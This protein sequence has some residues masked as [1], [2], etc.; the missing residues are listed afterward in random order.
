MKHG[1]VYFGGLSRGD[2][3]PKEIPSLGAAGGRP[4]LSEMT[5]KEMEK[6]CPYARDEY[7]RCPARH[8][9]M[10]LDVI[11][12]SDVPPG[13]LRFD[14]DYDRSLMT[15]DLDR[16]QPLLSHPS[17]TG[18]PIPWKDIRREEPEEVPKSRSKELYPPIKQKRR[19]QDMSLRTSDIDYAQPKKPI[20]R[21]RR[22]SNCIVDLLTQSYHF[23]SSEVPPQ[24]AFRASGRSSMDASDIDGTQ[25]HPLPAYSVDGNPLKLEDEFRHPRHSAV[26]A[27]AKA[28]L[29]PA[30]PR[31][32][33][34]AVSAEPEPPRR[35]EG[36]PV[37]HRQGHPLSPAITSPW[38]TAAPPPCT[39]A[40][41]ASGERWEMHRPPRVVKRWAT[42]TGASLRRRFAT[43]GRCSSTS[44]PKTCPARSPCAGW[45][46]YRT[47]STAPRA[48][49]HRA[50]PCRVGTSKV[51]RRTRGCE[52]REELPE[53]FRWKFH[54]LKQWWHEVT[55]S[56]DPSKKGLLRK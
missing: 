11:K 21:E 19:P 28:S 38:P 29:V 23:T 52:L 16:A 5:M 31:G 15:E 14:K 53:Q 18:A 8:E 55:W 33:G 34:H 50:L 56:H 41:N 54:Q 22:R 27:A 37:T 46:V 39:A 32:D 48:T 49:G 30:T 24:P 1:S 51:P 10:T 6:G 40:T 3:P 7:A 9:G 43:T 26:L 17:H 45:A 2:T 13:P 44:T 47:T 42:L 25:P 12:K 20:V 4:K 36:Q 35:M